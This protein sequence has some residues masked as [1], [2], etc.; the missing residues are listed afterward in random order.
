MT[1]NPYPLLA[2]SVQGISSVIYI[3]RP[4]SSGA[5]DM[6]SL[7]KQSPI[8]C[9]YTLTSIDQIGAFPKNTKMRAYYS[10]SNP[11]EGSVTKEISYT[12]GRNPN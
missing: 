7:I 1:T 10:V 11:L 3:I 9:W 2:T 8:V 6:W 12:V 5:D 4:E